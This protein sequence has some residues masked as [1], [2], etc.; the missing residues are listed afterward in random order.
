MDVK[1]FDKDG[2]ERDWA[3]LVANYGAIAI[4][5]PDADAY[6]K[7]VEI[8]EKH[9]DSAF[10]VKVLGRNGIPQPDIP[11]VFYWPDAPVLEDAGWLG[12]GVEGPTNENGDVGFGMGPGAYYTPPE[13]GPHKAWIKGSGYSEMFEGAGM[14]MGTNHNHVDITLQ[15]IE[16]GEEPEPEPEGDIAA[17]L[18]RIGDILERIEQNGLVIRTA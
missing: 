13:Q 8:R 3:W 7:V 12:R 5:T 18:A 17:Q 2:T 9:D 15:W 14:V 16:N 6:Y 11:V 1:V 10:I 4:Q